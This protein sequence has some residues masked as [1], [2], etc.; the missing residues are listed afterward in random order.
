MN[1]AAALPR[2]DY[3][4]VLMDPPWRT[5][6][7]SGAQRTP[8]QKRGDDHYPTMSAEQ[9]AAMDVAAIAA[10]DAVLAMWTLGSHLDQ[11]LALGRALGFVYV[12]D[13]F[14]WVKQRQLRPNQTDLFTDDVVA[15]PIGMGKYTRNQVEPCLLFKRG[16]GVKRASASV[17]QLIVAPRREH[18]R[19]PAEQY[20]RLE[21][22]FGPVPRAEIFSRT[23]RPG[24]D[25]WGN[26]TGK[27]EEA[28]A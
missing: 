24:W 28:A 10:P 11:A 25:A 26:E 13:L 6:L 4:L 22:L 3:R 17:R 12:T 1:L 27:F 16:K 20:E 8:T 14:Y 9:L 21:A 18:S 2:R 19:K 23:T 5:V 15:P 7:W